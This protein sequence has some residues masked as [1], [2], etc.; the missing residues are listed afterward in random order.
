VGKKLE[1][2]QIAKKLAHNTP[3]LSRERGPGTAAPASR[4]PDSGLQPALMASFFYSPGRSARP[5][6]ATAEIV[7]Q[8]WGSEKPR[9][10]LDRVTDET[11]LFDRA[12]VVVR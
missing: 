9:P 10:A 11:R 2:G 7:Y 3:F 8:L 5:R 1:K 4:D 6:R 12:A